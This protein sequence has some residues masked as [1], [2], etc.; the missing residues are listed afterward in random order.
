MKRLLTKYMR[1]K[2]TSAGDAKNQ[3]FSN[4]DVKMQP[5]GKYGLMA[6]NHLKLN[7]SLRFS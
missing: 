5:L 7:Q 4:Q 6:L 1:V 2:N 3:I